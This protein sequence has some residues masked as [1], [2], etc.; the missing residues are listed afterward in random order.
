MVGERRVS[1]PLRR[2]VYVANALS[3]SRVP[4]AL[5]LWIAPTRPWWVLGVIAVAGLTDVL[6]GAVV[7]WAQRKRWE[8]G[9]HGAFAADVARGEVLDGFADKVFTTSAVLALAFFARPP[10]WVLAA[11]TAREL[12]LL[13]PVLLYRLTP[14]ARRPEIDFTAGPVGKATTFFQLAAL[15]LGFL[16]QDA[17]EPTAALAGGLGVLAAILYV[18]RALRSRDAS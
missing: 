14:E 9:D 6:D 16:S 12:L 5:A 7:R 11:L 18:G 10:L 15:V 3:L 4:L 1:H 17:F 8:D 13:P 2:A